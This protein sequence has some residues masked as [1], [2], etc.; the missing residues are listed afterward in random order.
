MIYRS[1]RHD[2]FICISLP[3]SSC[4]VFLR[5]DLISYSLF[6]WLSLF[7]LALAREWR[8]LWTVQ[9]FRHPADPAR[10]PVL[11]KAWKALTKKKN[12]LISTD[13]WLLYDFLSVKNDA[14]VPSKSKKQKTIFLVDILKVPDEKSRIRSWIRSRIH[15]LGVGIRRSRSGSGSV[16]KCHGSGTLVHSNTEMLITT[17]NCWTQF[18][19]QW[20]DGILKH[21]WAITTKWARAL[22]LYGTWVRVNLDS[23]L[24]R[25]N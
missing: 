7:I 6:L 15:S 19:V 20:E 11:P 4:S 9:C 22:P 17:S 23:Q 8:P 2:V 18:L 3:I 21:Q 14:N 16:P 10:R 24:V 12:P 13:F 5:N 25:L 1:Y